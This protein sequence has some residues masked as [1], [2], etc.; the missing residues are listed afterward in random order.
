MIELVLHSA[1][2]VHNANGKSIGSAI[3]AQ[4]TAESPYTLQWTTLYPKI[5][6]SHRGIWTPI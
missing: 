1:H 6:P 5:A 3:S 2:R 4:L